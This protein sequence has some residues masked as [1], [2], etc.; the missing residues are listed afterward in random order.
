MTLGIHFLSWICGG[1][2][3]GYLGSTFAVKDKQ[4][5]HTRMAIVK[6]QLQKI[7]SIA[8]GVEKLEPSCTAGG[9][10]KRCNRYG[11]PFGVSSA[12]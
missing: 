8:E 9:N 5:A 10:G 2:A 3:A 11:G 12:S 4:F 6:Q 1:W 7:A